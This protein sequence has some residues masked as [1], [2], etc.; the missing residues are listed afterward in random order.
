MT[1]DDRLDNYKICDGTLLQRY[2]LALFYTSQND[3]FTFEDFSTY[4]ICDWPGVTCDS[5][6]TFIQNLTLNNLTGTLITEIGLLQSLEVIDL[7]NSN[8]TGSLITEIGHLVNLKM[9]DLS[10]NRL[11]GSIS[12]SIFT[13][14]PKLAVF[15]IFNNNLGGQIPKEMLKTLNLK[16]IILADNVFVNTLPIFLA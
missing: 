15:N 12:S 16:E 8:L 2:V 10:N 14:V 3:V 7:S 9:L 11:D 13:N 5:G 4:H 6:N 1:E